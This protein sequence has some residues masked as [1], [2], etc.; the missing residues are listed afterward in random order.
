GGV[1][2][3]D[4]AGT[5]RVPGA[6]PRQAYRGGGDWGTLVTAEGDR[7]RMLLTRRIPT[8]R[9]GGDLYRRDHEVHRPR[10]LPRAPVVGVLRIVGFRVRTLSSYGPQRLPPGLVGFLARKA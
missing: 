4:A 5:G 9:K 8:L 6:G 2:L 7:E 10:L 3:F 1:F